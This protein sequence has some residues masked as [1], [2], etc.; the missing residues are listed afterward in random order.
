LGQRDR[1]SRDQKRKAKLKKRAERSRKHET[2][3]YTGSKYKTDAYAAVFARTEIGIHESYIITEREL[4]DDEV[5]LAIETL[6]LRMRE[7]PLSPLDAT[8]VLTLHEGDEEELIIANIRRNWRILEERGGLP[9]RDDLIGV[10]RTLLNS[11]GIWRSRSLHSQGYLHYNEGFV[12]KMGISIRRVSEDRQPIPEPAEDPLL[13]LGRAW[14]EGG[15]REA[16]QE[17]ADQ[18]EML[19]RSSDAARVIDLSQQLLGENEDPSAIPLLQELAV[20]GHR[21]VNTQ[22]G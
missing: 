7:G 20:R 8:D 22:R 17:F 6:V 9:P 12:K 15:S 13:A 10:L 5:E 16:R 1:Q 3:A 4:I 11:I 14:T 21:A 18:I 2:L 19:L